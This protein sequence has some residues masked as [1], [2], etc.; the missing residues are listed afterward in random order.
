[1]QPHL[2][3]RLHGLGGQRIAPEQGVRLTCKQRFPSIGGWESDKALG[4]RM[5]ELGTRGSLLT[6]QERASWPPV[7]SASHLCLLLFP[8]LPNLTRLPP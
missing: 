4:R 3:K 1:M 7:N 2:Q 8:L 5:E 6:T